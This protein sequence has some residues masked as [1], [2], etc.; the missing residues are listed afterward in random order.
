LEDLRSLSLTDLEKI[1]SPKFKAKDIFRFIHKY[2]KE[3]ISAF[4]S[5]SL[6][7]RQKLSDKYMVSN[8]TPQK[9]LTDK[10]VQKVAFKLKDGQVVEAV[11]M[12]YA[13]ERNT[14]CVSSQV[15]CAIGCGF[16]ATGRMGFKRNLTVSEILSQV[17]YFARKEKVSNVVFMGMGEPFLNY[18]NALSAARFLNH[19]LGLNIAA[20]K[21]VFSTIGITAGIF[22]LAEE[23]EQFRL[24]WSMVAPLDEIRKELIPSKFREPVSRIVQAIRSYQKKTDRRVTIEYMVLKDLN[25]RKEDLRALT[26]IAKDLDSHINLIPYNPL[27]E[28][29]KFKVGNIRLLLNELQKAG[30]NVT[31]RKSLGQSIKAACGQLAAKI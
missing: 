21:I 6:A 1:I 30:L 23:K 13:G 16:C 20:R 12:E 8:L 27:G 2:L 7:E 24:A 10:G 14:I 25:D 26:A 3:D 15:G 5:L 19:P 22:K 28:V 29:S 17:Y 4:S 9:T 31:V 18:K 11:S